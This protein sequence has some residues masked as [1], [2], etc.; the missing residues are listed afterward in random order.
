MMAVDS[1]TPDIPPLRIIPASRLLPD[2]VLWGARSRLGEGWSPRWVLYGAG[3]LVI[4]V[5]DVDELPHLRVTCR[6]VGTGRLSTR[7]LHRDG[8]V[9]IQFYKGSVGRG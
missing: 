8:E 3:C 5:V 1:T 9:L 6:Q 4:H 2:D 7:E